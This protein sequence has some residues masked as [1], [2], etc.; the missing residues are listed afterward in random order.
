MRF[1]CKGLKYFAI[2]MV[3]KY[4][5]LWPH[6]L[7]RLGYELQTTSYMPAAIK[8]VKRV[9]SPYLRTSIFEFKYLPATTPI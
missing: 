9:V 2:K 8:K 6:G 4:E 7:A 3:M 1:V 5:T